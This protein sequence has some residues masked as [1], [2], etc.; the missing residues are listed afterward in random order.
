[1]STYT[2]NELKTDT[3]TDRTE[4]SAFGSALKANDERAMAI[5]KTIKQEERKADV[6]LTRDQMLCMADS[7]CMKKDVAG[8]ISD[9]AAIVNL[10]HILLT[11][12]V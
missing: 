5:S 8:R 3:L 1:M 12:N 7:K 11:M 6:L 4:T 10:A 9:I 2:Q